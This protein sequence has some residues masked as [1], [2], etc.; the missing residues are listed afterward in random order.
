MRSEVWLWVGNGKEKEVQ[1]GETVLVRLDDENGEK[2][3]GR[4]VARGRERGMGAEV[5]L[6]FEK[7]VEKAV[8]KDLLIKRLC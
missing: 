7:G 8:C 2:R 5:R 1:E 4:G 6:W 3:E